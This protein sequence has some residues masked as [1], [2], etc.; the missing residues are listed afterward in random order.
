MAGRTQNP[1]KISKNGVVF[2]YDGKKYKLDPDISI[3]IQ[4]DLGADIIFAFDECTSPLHG[5]DYNKKSLKKLTVGRKNAWRRK[6]KTAKRCTASPK[7]EF[8]KI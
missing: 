1:V 5:Y 4:E 7:E 3:K 6:G 2:V 8:L